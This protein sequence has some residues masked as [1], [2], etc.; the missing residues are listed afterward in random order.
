MA[1]MISNCGHDENGNY[2][3]GQAGDQTGTEWQ[4]IAWYNRP[5][6][7]VLRHPDATVRAKIAELAKKAA[8]NNKIGYDQYQRDTFGKELAKVGYDPAKITTPCETDCSKGVIDIVK[9]V[10][11]L[12]GK[13]ALVNVNATYTGNMRSGFKAA[14]FT[15]LTETKYRTSGDYL[16][17]GD[18]LLNDNHHTAT[19]VSDGAKAGSNGGSNNGS[20]NN[21]GNKD[22]GTEEVYEV[23]KGDTLSAI[24]SKYGTTYQKLASYNGIANPDIINAGQKIRIPGTGITTYEVKKGDTLWAIAAAK[25][26]DGQ[27]YREI[28]TLNG[29]T[30]T[31][32]H[33]GDALKIPAK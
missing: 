25:L 21:G 29:L 9:A 28:M 24:A 5:W 13:T 26:G 18:I 15:V 32:I 20:G 2:H 16:L 10:G 33:A 6:D 1:T 23:K 8:N 19:V 4:I 31:F 11:H 30:S 17:A 12:L 22:N 7:C 14:G 27:R 3:G